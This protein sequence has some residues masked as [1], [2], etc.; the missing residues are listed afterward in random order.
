MDIHAATNAVNEEH[1]Q[2]EETDDSSKVDFIEIVPLSKDT[3]DSC[4]SE[5]VSGD[6]SAEVIRENLADV[7]QGPDNV[8]CAVLYLIFILSRQ[9]EVNEVRHGGRLL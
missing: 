7:K 8:C 6:R 2:G 3:V 9:M 5:R 1:S 4:S